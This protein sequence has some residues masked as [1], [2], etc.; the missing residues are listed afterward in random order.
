MHEGVVETGTKYLITVPPAW[1]GTLL[2]YAYGPFVRPDEPA[3][4]ADQPVIQALLRRKFALAGCAATRFWPLEENIPNQFLLADVFAEQ[5]GA[6]E[7]TI[8]FGQSI[9]GLLSASLVQAHPGR[10]DGALVVCGTLGGGIGTQNQQLDCTFAFKT[11]VAP[12]SPIELVRITDPGR[13]V[14]AALAALEQAQR[15][16]QGRARIGLAASLANISGW[17]DPLTPAPGDHAARQRGQYQWLVD[18]DFQVFLG[19]RAVL[20]RRGGGNMSWNTGVDYR[21]VL[22]ASA[23][24]EDVIRLYADAG[25]DLDTDLRALEQA[26]R[27]SADPP[28]VDYFQRHI[29]FDGDLGGTPV[30]TLHSVGDGL[31]PVDHMQSYA[32]VVAWAGNSDLLTSLYTAR[33]GHCSF[34]TSE[35]LTAL[36]VLTERVETG[37]WPDLDPDGLNARADEQFAG[38]DHQ[39]PP[40]IGTLDL[41]R[42]GEPAAPAFVSYDPPRMVRPH[43]VR[44]V[45]GR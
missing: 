28:A 22:D 11:L 21:R 31:V 43:D 37:R 29:A 20:E 24:A 44:H 5:V 9:G 26:P 40:A 17:Y 32:D 27:I 25:L 45:R 15:T 12:D 8:A 41:R 19:A 4:P 39:L 23:G 35:T 6:P 10:L 33:G 38:V 2:L 36:D 1:N 7:R 13:N 14:D 34:P 3:W 16:A 30:V 42:G 18:P